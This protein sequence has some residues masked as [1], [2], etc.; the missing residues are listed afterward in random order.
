MFA[1]QLRAYIEAGLRLVGR[2]AD[3]EYEW[4]GPD[5]RWGRAEHAM[6]MF[7]HQDQLATPPF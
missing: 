6:M 3:G 4:A 1:Y 2:D 5:D 7:E